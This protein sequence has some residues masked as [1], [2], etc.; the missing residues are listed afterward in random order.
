MKQQHA[1]YTFS[2][3]SSCVSIKN[4]CEKYYIWSPASCSCQS[5]KY[6][7]SIIDDSAITCD[8]IMDVEAKSK[9][10]ETTFPTNFNEKKLA[11]KHKIS[12]FWLH[13]Y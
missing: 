6:L 8:E 12:I 5:G 2:L 9:D 4:V 3:N 7:A 1:L 10:E 13:F 11:V